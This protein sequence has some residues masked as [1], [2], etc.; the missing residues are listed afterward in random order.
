MEYVSECVTVG[1]EF[2]DETKGETA[3]EIQKVLDV[4]V[5]KVGNFIPA[6]QRPAMLVWNCS[7]LTEQQTL[8]IF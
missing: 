1:T 2:P 6:N 5:K 7:I 4:G 8:L 3:E